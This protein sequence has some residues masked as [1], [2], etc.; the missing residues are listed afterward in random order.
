MATTSG[1]LGPWS[2][3]RVA[4]GTAFVVAVLTGCPG[5]NGGV[6][7]ETLMHGGLERTY[8]IF[9][10][11]A[12]HDDVAPPLVLVLHG[13]RGNAR[14][15][16]YLT[17][18]NAIAEREG[19]VVVYPEGIGNQWNDGRGVSFGR[20]DFT[21]VD[22]VGF[23]NSLL[24]TVIAGY[25]V[26]PARVYV[27]GASNGGMMSHRLAC[28][29]SH[30]FAAAAP[31]IANM[32][33]PFADTCDP[34]EPISILAINGTDDALV[35][36]EG[37]IV[38]R[39]PDRGRVISVDETIALWLEHNGITSEPEVTLLPDTDPDDGTRVT[40]ERHHGDNGIDVV[41]YRVDGGGHTWPGGPAYQR[42]RLLG[43]VSR[44][45]SASETIWE[46]F[47]GL[48]EIGTSPARLRNSAA[49]Q[50]CSL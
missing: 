50:R 7:Y 47:K 34:T 40:R 23:I 26:D 10:P 15:M 12:L 3:R 20:E 32:P 49:P 45:F 38:A 22:D 29:L 37:G 21:D 6:R 16:M 43:T 8:A 13:G 9:V 35:P 30:R 33:E 42:Q 36:Y 2:A 41:L 48:P 17:G 5:A 44:D 39:D 11:S 31:V 14:K 27:T 19:F 24:D 28:E 1:K 18:F 4:L 46:F 25:G